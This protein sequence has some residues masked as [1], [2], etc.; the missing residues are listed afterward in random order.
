MEASGEMVCSWNS[1][2]II[3]LIHLQTTTP[4]GPKDDYEDVDFLFMLLCISLVNCTH[5]C[6]SLAMLSTVGVSQWYAQAH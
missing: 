3:T 4:K 1:A 2:C 5:N 6:L